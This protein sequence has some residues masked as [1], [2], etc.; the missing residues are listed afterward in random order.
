MQLIKKDTQIKDW[1]PD[2]IQI[3]MMI[4]IINVIIMDKFSRSKEENFE[5]HKDGIGD[6]KD[7]EVKPR[8]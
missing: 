4:I 7:L 2:E 1:S 8:I 5:G 3:I 6:V